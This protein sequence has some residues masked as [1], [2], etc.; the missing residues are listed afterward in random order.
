M[1]KGVQMWSS[2]LENVQNNP[3]A[4]RSHPWE[5]P[6]YAWQGLQIDFAGPYLDHS[7]LVVVDAYS[8]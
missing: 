8:K 5:C 1:Y 2:M 6:K 4:L 3:P 7:Y